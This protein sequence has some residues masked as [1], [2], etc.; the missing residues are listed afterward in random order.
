MKQLKPLNILLLV[1]IAAAAFFYYKNKAAG[2]NVP[3]KQDQKDH[4][5]K[6]TNGPA[7]QP[8]RAEGLNR[9]VSNLIYTKHAR[10][11]MD[12]R[13]I[14]ET[15]V[16]EILEKGEINLNKSELQDARGPKY[17][18]EGITH[19]RQHVRIIFAQDP[20]GTAV[21]TVIDLDTEWECDCR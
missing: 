4:Q 10:C 19:D 17:A 21:I 6:T 18:V 11:R 3:V 8:T 9:R 1:L 14:D 20:E 12:C 5:E 16:K 13:H 15:E 7:D 2:N